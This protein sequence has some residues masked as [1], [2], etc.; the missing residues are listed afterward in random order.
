M[1][2]QRVACVQMTSSNDV[3]E[4]LRSAKKYIIEAAAAG[5]AMVVLPEMFAIMDSDALSKVKVAEPAGKGMIQDF[6]REEAVR[7]KVWLIGGTIPI[8]SAT[9]PNKIRAATL[10]FADD[11]ELKARYDKIHLFDVQLRKTNENYME[12]KTTEPGDKVVVLDTPVGRVGLA[13]CYDVRFPEFFRHMQVQ[14]AEII[15]LPTAFTYTTGVLHWDVL[16]RARAIENQVYMVAACQSGKHSNGRITYGHSMIVNPW[17][18]V[19]VCMQQGNGIITDDLDIAYVHSLR[20]DFP[21]LRH[22][23]L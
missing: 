5:A 16:V 10:V 14:G 11:G 2:Q 13:V 12:S 1:Q 9:D 3:A 17:G 15:L 19:K 22:R 4:N 18:E 8:A 20:E 6:L 23:R 21:V 7:N